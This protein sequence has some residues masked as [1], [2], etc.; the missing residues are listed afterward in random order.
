MTVQKNQGKRGKNYF[1]HR[2]AQRERNPDSKQLETNDGA[3]I[4]S[5]PGKNYFVTEKIIAKK[6]VSRR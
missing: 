4:I 1:R 5:T 2:E 3:I 6:I